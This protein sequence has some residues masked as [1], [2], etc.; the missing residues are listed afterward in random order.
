MATPV[1][2]RRL[3]VAFETE[4][5]DIHLDRL[6]IFIGLHDLGKALAGFQAKREQRLD[7]GQ[8]HTAE[9]LAVLTARF[10]SHQAIRFDLLQ[11]WV[12]DPA[13]ALFCTICHHGE[14]VANAR[15]GEHISSVSAQL[16]P[17]IYGHDPLA[18]IARL[19]EAL[20]EA[21]S[22]ALGDA[23]MLTMTPS[24]QHLLAGVAMAADWMGSDADLFVY[25][26]GQDDGRAD[27]AQRIAREL[28]RDTG[29]TGWARAVAGDVLDGMTPRPAQAAMAD[30]PIEQ[31]TILEDQTGAGK[32]EAA[33]VF[34]QRLVDT[35]LVDGIYFAVPSRSAATELH[36]RIADI[37]RRVWPNVAG[38]VVRAVPGLID[39]DIRELHEPSHSWAVG[40]PKRVMAAAVAVGTID[41]AMLS[42]LRV[43]HAW[44]RAAFLTRSLLIIDEAHASDPY[45]TE[46][47]ASLVDRHVSLGA[48]IAQTPR[49]PS[50]SPVQHD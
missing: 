31:I 47:I 14:P 19:T 3:S 23:P 11:K 45:M 15:I 30:L 1:L 35:G 16:R 2:R 26:C 21:F 13:A 40:S 7:N 24:S 18:E 36:S 8:G 50:S 38:R 48:S 20:L 43:R 27:E 12:D 42:H 29:I 37:A 39:T 5:T 33:M 9:G 28:I 22:G 6:E 34:A 4:L 46:I 32:T 25:A 49:A 44:M 41:Q 10:E 17:T